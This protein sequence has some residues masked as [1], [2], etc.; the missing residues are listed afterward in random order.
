MRL[1]NRSLNSESFSKFFNKIPIP[2]FAWHIV[3]EE[4]VL[5][6]F[7]DATE[8]LSFEGISLGIK[9]SEL[10]K[11][12]KKILT[13]LF[14]CL[15]EK[16]N[17]SEDLEVRMKTTDDLKIL[18]TTYTFLLPD[19]VIFHVEDITMQKQVRKALQEARDVLTGLE[20]II[21]QSPAVV[22]LIR[23]EEGWPVEYITDN[24]RQFGYEPSDFYSHILKFADLIH[25]DDLK[26]V[27]TESYLKCQNG[28]NEFVQEYRII[29]KL[30]A[31]RWIN[32][33]TWVKRDRDNN[34]TH[35]QGIILDITERRETEEKLKESDEK[36]R[37]I[38]EQSLFGVAIF[39]KGKVKYI[40][41]ALAEIAEFEPKEV[42]KWPINEFVKSI[43]PEDLPI[44]ME[45][46]Q[47]KLEENKDTV[48]RYVFRILTKSKKIKWLE[49]ISKT[50]SYQGD[51]AIL[52]TL[53]DV[54]EKK[55]ADI[56]LIESEEN[57]KKLNEVLEQ[58]VSERT[59]DLK[60]SEEK[61]R[62]LYNETPI[63]IGTATKDGKVIAMNKTMEEIVGYG[64]KELSEMGISSLYVNSNRREQLLSILQKESRVQDFEVRLKRKD[65]TEFL[66]LM[67]TAIIEL[68][69]EKIIHTTVRDITEIKKA[70]QKL[71]ESEKKYREIIESIEEGYFEVDLKGNYIFVNNFH[72]NY[73]GYSKEEMIGTNYREYF[74]EE[75][76]LKIFKEFNKVYVNNLKKAYFETIVR[77][78]D[79]QQRY[80][81]GYLYLKYNSEGEKVGFF[82]FT[83]DFT[84][85]KKAESQL[86]FLSR[87]VEQASEGIAI[88][89]L[90][91]NLNYLN[92]AFASRHG[93]TKGESIGKHLSIFHTP[94]QLSSVEKANQ[95]IQERGEFY[96]EI[97]HKHRD[98]TVFPTL[99]HNSIIL[100]DQG[101][102]IGML[103][104]F[105]DITE[106][107][108]V[109]QKLRESEEK[110][111]FISENANDLICLVDS[112]WRFQY[113]NE[114]FKRILGYDPKELIGTFGF[115]IIH[116]EDTGKANEQ[117]RKSFDM[118]IGKTVVRMKRKD[119][120]YRWI[121]SSIRIFY[122]EDK[123]FQQSIGVSR[124]ITER[125]EAEIKLKESELKYK[126]AYNKAEFY[127]DIF[128]H[129]INNI[130]SNI[131]TSIE[132]S[133]MYL[134]DPNRM[135]DVEKLYEVI[136]GQ[137]KKGSSL[138]SN[139]RKLSQIEDSVSLVKPVEI[140][141]V[142]IKEIDFTLKSYQTQ[143]VKIRTHYFKRGTLVNANDL[144]IDLFNNLFNNS[145]KY[146]DSRVVEIDVK[147]SREKKNN[148]NYIKL[149]FLDN[150]IGIPDKRK[151]TLFEK[152]HDKDISSKGLGIGLTLVKKIVE[153]YK[154]EVWVEDR[155]KGDYTQGSNFI[156]LIPEAL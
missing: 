107:K 22:I 97:W 62:F 144:L 9:A 3:G 20:L 42:K 57:L 25:P 89:D 110:Y 26:E 116:Q 90:N 8:K 34:I 145:I 93:F 99:M 102:K 101:E 137:F 119:G 16:S 104:T 127:K 85:R 134:K 52:A 63:G 61:Y 41:N 130:L 109:E 154:G 98:G 153:S 92:E 149:E 156:V 19:L 18:S 1:K 143:D 33:S 139:I 40:N 115:N 120:I 151:E 69:G 36:F 49:I 148:T 84:E 76:A 86:R 123:K 72:S 45:N 82:G 68:K 46:M 70:E 125:K 7:N 131:K 106:Q 12:D 136:R 124:D 11:D 155:I 112:K 32:I 14:R 29:S 43:Y 78:R 24:I 128:T 71:K 100:D 28:T 129:D 56:K 117:V 4:L 140:N 44:I 67:D 146:N 50:I 73:F 150:G 51:L 105:V 48:T 147:M 135:P 64:I 122:D 81:E 10:F 35:F 103:G 95:E 66:A 96:G 113:C 108:E 142:L 141:D 80:N 27:I 83:R 30:G 38:T 15:R 94:E 65:G 58:K 39:Q 6:D 59:R 13:N 114:A 118:G 23:N 17:F 53:I 74:Q 87:A 126:E 54:T 60:K 2:T 132:L 5:I 47:V 88:A 111:R 31:H 77:R 79:G 55:E 121:E 133:A 75:E 37:K 21:N 138:V 152:E 91:G